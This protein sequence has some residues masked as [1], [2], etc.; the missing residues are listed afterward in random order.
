MKYEN[1]N[2]ENQ[3]TCM[4]KVFLLP[5]TVLGPCTVSINMVFK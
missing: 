4:Q 2:F 3:I 1:A 5:N